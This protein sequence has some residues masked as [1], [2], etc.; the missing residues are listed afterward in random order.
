[1]DRCGV[2]SGVC[3]ADRATSDLYLR[4]DERQI[5]T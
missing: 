5:A 2:V 1:M 3:R 4:K